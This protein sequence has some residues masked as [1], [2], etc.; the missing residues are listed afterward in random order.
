[1]TGVQLGKAVT[2]DAAWARQVQQRLSALENPVQQRIGSFVLTDNNSGSLVAH[3]PLMTP[4]VLAGA[5]G[6][7]TLLQQATAAATSTTTSAAATVDAATGL[8]IGGVV[9]LIQGLLQNGVQLAESAG[10]TGLQ[11]FFNLLAGVL[12]LTGEIEYTAWEVATGLEG[13][14]TNLSTSGVLALAGLALGALPSGITLAVGG[15][16]GLATGI[17]TWLVSGG[18][19]PSGVSLAIS[20]ITGLATGI[21]SWLAG[22]GALPSG[23]TLA[24]TA[25]SGLGSGVSSF[26][27]S[28][29]AFPVADITG[30]ATGIE[31]WLASG[32]GLPSGATLAVSGLTGLASGIESWLASGGGLPSGATLA[33]S[34]LTGL[35]S[36]V[37][38]FLTSALAFP[39]ADITGLASGIETWL[40]GGG[41]LPSGVTLA[42]SGLTGLASGV[43][44]WLASGGALPSG[45]SLAVSEVSGLATGIESWLA[46][47]GALPSGATLAVSEVTGLASGIEAWLASGGGL[48]SGVTLAG[49]QLT[50]TVSNAIVSSVLGGASLGS[51]VESYMSSL[52]STF[53]KTLPWTIGTSTNTDL[54][55]LVPLTKFQQ[56]VDGIVNNGTSGNDVTAAVAAFRQGLVSAQSAVAQT[57]VDGIFGANSNTA[58]AQGLQVFPNVNV[59]S[60]VEG[61]E[62]LGADVSSAF[63]GFFNL[64]GGSPLVGSS[65]Q[66]VN[67]MGLSSPGEYVAALNEHITGTGSGSSGVDVLINFASYPNSSTLPSIFSESA[68]GVGISAGAAVVNAPGGSGTTYVNYVTPTD[69]DYQVVSMTLGSLNLLGG[70]STE[71]TLIGRANSAMTTMVYFAMYD[72]TGYLFARVA[73]VNTVLKSIPYTPVVGDYQLECGNPETSTL[74]EFNVFC[75]GIPILSCIDSGAV[76]QYGASNRLSGF[77]MTS[78][79]AGDYPASVNS[80]GVYDNPPPAAVGSGFRQY[81]ASTTVV[82]VGTGAGVTLLPNNFFDTNQQC[83]SDITSEPGSNNQITVSVSGWYSVKVAVYTSGT[84]SGQLTGVALYHNGSVVDMG[85][86]TATTGN[87]VVADKFDVYC[88]AGDTL[89]PG[90]YTSYSGGGF[91]LQG[92]STGTFCYWSVTFANSGTIS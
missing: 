39:V 17:E 45:V 86:Q 48:P 64:L 77:W 74:L 34:G 87:F 14:L 57:V 10:E 73:G 22:G 70:G 55:E 24:A 84:G 63:S 8:T 43:E 32:G 35:G 58:V 18:S 33:V 75:N 50:G 66:A 67:A 46:G 71:N 42:V 49:S 80:W 31:T 76:S 15:L 90:F 69:T 44:T 65:V 28:A 85:N 56:L 7:A 5:D 16:T 62:N 30:L 21:E 23:V 13:F 83:T 59:T 19:L 61:G 89:Q 53:P 1:M 9:S 4:T 51:D 6:F 79:G 92:E 25:L 2:T 20:D 11:D 81:R 29:L 37:S 60:V 52:G 41:A 26:L 82:G 91:A 47:G 78:A 12:D 38:S 88:E 27:T 36:G 68:S 3:S 40:T 72:G 54:M